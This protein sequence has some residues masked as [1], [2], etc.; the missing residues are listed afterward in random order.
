MLSFFLHIPW[1][2]P[3]AWRVLP[4]AWRER[5]LSG[6]LGNDVVAFHTEGFARNFLLCAQELP[7]LPVDLQAMTVDLGDRRVLA[8][9]Y[10]ISIDA[11]AMQELAASP[12]VCR[13]ARGLREGFTTDG[14]Q[15]IL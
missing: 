7:G 9:H 13:H 14:R 3:D 5:L 4:P 15:L 1:P 11:A 8:R 12:A 2:G 10:P 6:L